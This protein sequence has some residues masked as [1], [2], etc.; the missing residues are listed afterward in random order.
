MIEEREELKNSPLVEAVKSTS[1]NIAELSKEAITELQELLSLAGF[2]PGPIDGFHG[3]RTA[4]AWKLFKESEHMTLPELIG[5]AS[6]GLLLARSA[7]RGKAASNSLTKD[8][9]P[10]SNPQSTPDNPNAL[11]PL[12][13][14]AVVPVVPVA[15]GAPAIP[16]PKPAVKPA[17]RPQTITVPGVSA[18][19]VLY[20]PIW[21]SGK[22]TH[23]TWA[24][25]TK[26]G[27]RIP[28]NESITR[29]IIRLAEYMDEVRA[30]LGDRPIGV[31][32]WYRDPRTNRAIGGASKS[33]HLTGQA[34]DFYVVGESVVVTFNKL[35]RFHDW[36][37]LA[38]GNSFIHLDTRSGPTARWTYPG[39]PKVDLW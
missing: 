36:G 10:G 6:L 34:V 3:P 25:A 11:P 19:V 39:G 33:M 5:S 1:A 31:T 38:V 27:Q 18:P 28:V 7:V 24:E 12:P 4:A 20:G 21:A 23:F 8:S 35:K 9:G 30:F 22:P 37:G 26:N 13:A 2:D 17:P 14:D 16:A 32:S 15:P 29:N